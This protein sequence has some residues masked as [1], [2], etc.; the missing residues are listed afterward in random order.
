MTAK[1][2][3]L[4]PFKNPKTLP[5]VVPHKPNQT[6]FLFQALNNCTYSWGGFHK[7]IYALRQA[8][9][10]CAETLSPKRASQKFGAERKMALC[11]T[12]SLYEIDPYITNCVS[13]YLFLL[14]GWRCDRL[15]Q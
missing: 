10:L 14:S 11:P 7:L 6:D 9:T 5:N 3:L 8:L 13:L 2:A 12:F 1:F 4:Q 15:G